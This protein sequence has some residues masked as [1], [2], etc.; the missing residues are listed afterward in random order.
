MHNDFVR[1]QTTSWNRGGSVVQR[2]VEQQTLDFVASLDAVEASTA[3]LP[4]FSA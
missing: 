4:L 3:A 2:E 1:G